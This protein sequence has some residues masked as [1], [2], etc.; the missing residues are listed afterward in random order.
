MAL[1]VG[2]SRLALGGMH[3]VQWDFNSPNFGGRNIADL[4]QKHSYPFGILVKIL[5]KGFWM[6]EQILEIIHMQNMV[7]KF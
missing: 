2:A 6:K 1:D 4:F 3:S 5:G 7:E